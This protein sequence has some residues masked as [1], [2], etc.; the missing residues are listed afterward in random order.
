MSRTATNATA[1]AENGRQQE[2]WWPDEGEYGPSAPRHRKPARP[3]AEERRFERTDKSPEP[4]FAG[5]RPLE[6]RPP[7]RQ[8]EADVRAA[9]SLSRVLMY[10]TVALLMA[11][12]FVQVGRLAQIASQA[13]RISTL[14]ASIRELQ[15]EK[16]N[17]QVRL[18]MQQ[19]PT[20]VL[21][22]AIYR[23]GM[24]RPED[25]QIRVITPIGGAFTARTQTADNTF[26]VDL[27][28]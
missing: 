26:G 17:L 12:L 9:P 25:G 4:R 23:L 10:L 1:R 20:R 5:S 8:P 18:S 3:P 7:E 6:P 24:I 13:K 27:S 14:Q 15:N 28:E 11:L 2:T 22:E 21:E 19:N 16:G